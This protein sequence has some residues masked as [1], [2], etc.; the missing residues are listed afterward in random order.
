MVAILWT[1]A[2]I[3]WVVF[4]GTVIKDYF[5]TQA[6]KREAFRRDMEYRLKQK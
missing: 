1:L 5:Q 6:D 2:I 3:V 4:I